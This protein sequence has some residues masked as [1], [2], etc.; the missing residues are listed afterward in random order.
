MIAVLCVLPCNSRY[1][2]R[3]LSRSRD[4]SMPQSTVNEVPDVFPSEFHMDK[5][6]TC[7]KQIMRDWSELGAA[8]RDAC[9]RPILR[10]LVNIY[11]TEW[12]VLQSVTDW[13]TGTGCFQG[14]HSW[15][16]RSFL[17][18]PVTKVHRDR[19]AEFFTQHF[20][21]RALGDFL[22]APMCPIKEVT[23]YEANEFM[24]S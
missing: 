23:R 24:D 20:S 17:S 2:W 7:L 10:E 22:I 14:S 9:Y 19:P 4:L 12:L 21:G 11:P 6:K 8:E 18:W 13:T 3:H 1:R 5:V 15:N 16:I